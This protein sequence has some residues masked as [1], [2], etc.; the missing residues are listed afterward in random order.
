[1]YHSGLDLEPLSSLEDL[2]CVHSVEPMIALRMEQMSL[3]RASALPPD[4]HQM[5]VILS[6]RRMHKANEE[7]VQSFAIKIKSHLQYFVVHIYSTRAE[8]NSF[9]RPALRGSS[10]RHANAHL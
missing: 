10:K 4:Y 9:R 1:M 8:M 2:S 6:N 3:T 7:N 5:K